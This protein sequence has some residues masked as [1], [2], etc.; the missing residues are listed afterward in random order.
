MTACPSPATPSRS[1]PRTLLRHGERRIEVL[2]DG[3]GGP[4]LVMLPSSLRD[5]LD[6]GDV[7]VRIAAAG[8][9]VLRP[10]PRGMGASA[11]PLDG[12]TLSDL[13][14]DVAVVI[15]A[16]GGGR[17][18]VAGHAFGHFVA[19][20]T[21]LEHPRQVRG[22]AVLAG[23]A[24]VFPAG[25]TASLDIASDPARPADE[26]LD[27]LRR[28]FFAPG[29]DPTPWLQG[30]HPA[31]RDTYRRA[32]TSPPKAQWWPVSEVPILDLQADAD[33]WRPPGTRDELRAVLGE[34]VSVALIRDAS[35]ALLPEQ[36]A[37]VA[38]AIVAWAT[39]LPA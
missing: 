24:R 4:A 3:E 22:V 34:R 16:L 38:E 28:A 36:P 19:R 13:A 9:R 35:H 8:F 32:S 1:A 37:A 26:R 10:Q 23:A 30:W 29:H 12:L 33:P 20:V 6:L 25:L 7:A 17:A 15:D 39:S 11:G 21:A 31:L 2:I 14:D 27:H 18:I 5:S